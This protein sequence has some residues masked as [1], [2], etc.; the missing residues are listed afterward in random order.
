M[1]RLNGRLSTVLP[2]FDAV[3]L[4]RGINVKLGKRS[5]QEGLLMADASAQNF[6]DSARLSKI[7]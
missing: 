5:V 7:I 1:V 2:D 4:A 6:G 3:P